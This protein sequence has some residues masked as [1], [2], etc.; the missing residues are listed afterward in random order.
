MR[1]DIISKVFRRAFLLFLIGVMV[2]SGYRIY[3][4]LAPSIAANN[5][6]RDLS[7]EYTRP[8]PTPPADDAADSAEGDSSAAVPVQEE[9]P[10][11]VPLDVDWDALRKT[12]SDIVGWIYVDGLP[13]ISYPVLRGETND[14]YIHT[15]FQGNYRYDGSIF[16]D[17][18]C[19]PDWADAN[20]I[21][22]GHSMRVG[23][24]FG[25]LKQVCSQE[26]CNSTPYFWILT[27]NGNYRYKI[28]SAAYVNSWDDAYRL[29]SDTDN[30]FFKWEQY[31]RDISSVSTDVSLDK[32]DKVVVLST[33]A[34][35]GKN[36]FIVSGKCVS[37]DVPVRWYHR[38]P[39]DES[40]VSDVQDDGGTYN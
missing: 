12:N 27:P 4:I 20:T 36:R 18:S 9:G 11:V 31:I 5:E 33:C 17:S 13:N 10:A 39:L 30:A 22:Y 19:A 35:N 14:D 29:F 32:N 2:Y 23:T 1:S 3:K 37:D 21:V 28:F 24:M 26:Y 7:E 34:Y 15:T 6:Y 40:S 16:M 8:R 38:P 25:R